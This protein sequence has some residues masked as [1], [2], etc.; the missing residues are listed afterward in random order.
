VQHEDTVTK[1]VFSRNGRLIA[2]G[3]IDGG[4]RVY[5]PETGQLIRAIRHGGQ[6][7]DIGFSAADRYLISISHDEFTWIDDI[8][9]E[10]QTVTLPGDSL[11]RPTAIAENGKFIAETTADGFVRVHETESGRELA[12][13]K[14]VSKLVAAAV[15]PDGSLLAVADEGKILRLYDVRTR[16]ERWQVK[17]FDTLLSIRFSSDGSVVAYGGWSDGIA[18]LDARTNKRIYE[19]DT[20]EVTAVAVANDRKVM[21]AACYGGPIYLYLGEEFKVIEQ[22]GTLIRAM[23]FRNDGR[24]LAVLSNDQKVN[25]YELDS[26]RLQAVIPLATPAIDV[27]FD[28]S[29]SKLDIWMR[30]G[31]EIEYREELLGT[32]DLMETSCKMVRQN[33]SQEEWKLYFPDKQCRAT[34]EKVKRSCEVRQQ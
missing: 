13:I 27:S 11:E 6:V 28:A 20:C 14:F 21:A 5:D 15:S 3:N 18:L 7:T 32:E 1:V 29:G 24:S 33:M 4:C 8:V 10:R 9:R 16:E 17:T 22:S 2:T 23:A 34:C 12:R 25:V 19:Q 30:R 26:R 31:S